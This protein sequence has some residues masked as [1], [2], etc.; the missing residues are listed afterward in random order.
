[1]SVAGIHGYSDT[2]A[3][4]TSMDLHR[5]AI[6]TAA[7]LHFNGSNA[8]LVRW[9]GG[10]HVGEHHDH[11]D[12]IRCLLRAGL[13]APVLHNIRRIFQSGIPAYCNDKS[14]ERNVLAY[15]AYGNHSTM[16]D[17][18]TKAYAAGQRIAVAASLFCLTPELCCCCTATSPPGCC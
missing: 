6:L 9:I 12:I 17:N 11:L 18:P 7:L 14:D 15:Y 5:L 1:M 2:W 16:N 4:D 10:P 13:G 3:S 8:N